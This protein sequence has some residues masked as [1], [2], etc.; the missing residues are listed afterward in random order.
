MYHPE[1]FCNS[2]RLSASFLPMF[3]KQIL[4]QKSTLA[5]QV[6]TPTLSLLMSPSYIVFS[7][8]EFPA[9]PETNEAAGEGTMAGFTPNTIAVPIMPTNDERAKPGLERSMRYHK[10][11]LTRAK[12]REACKVDCQ[13]S[14]R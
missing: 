13:G 9:L 11:G 5:T 1:I 6:Q 7:T 4:L 8:D 3:P 10:T 12:V 2:G 14:F